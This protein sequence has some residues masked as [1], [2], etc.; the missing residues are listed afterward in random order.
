MPDAKKYILWGAA[1]HALVLAEAISRT[2]GRVVALVDNDPDAVS[3]LSGI[4]V[5]TGTAGFIRWLEQESPRGCMLY[6]LVAIGGNRGQDRIDIQAMMQARGIAFPS[7]THPDATVH[8]GA[9][10]GEGTQV[11]AKSLIAAGATVGRA[12]IINHRA[13]VDHEC[14]LGDGVHVAPGATLCGC[15]TLEDNVLVGA[16]A[17]ILPRVRVGANSTIGAGAVVI[18]DVPSNSVVVGNPARLVQHIR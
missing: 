12:C 6:G 18:R 5:H 1:G 7:L 13:G 17:V 3:P 10:I 16:G 8:T 2:G 9:Q 4:P 15:V 11:L 14:R